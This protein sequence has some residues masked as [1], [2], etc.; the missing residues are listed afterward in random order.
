[1][2]DLVTIASF[3][4][5]AEAETLRVVLAD[6]GIPAFVSDAEVSSINF[7]MTPAVGGV[8][9][10]TSTDDAARA[11]ALIAAHGGYRY[12]KID[13]ESADG[14][15]HCLDC[16]A[17]I[18]DDETTCKKCGWSYAVDTPEEA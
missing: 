8:K 13:Y 6:E 2:S 15:M 9:L 5:A 7:L 16:G 1:M 14:S 4:T 3:Y 18:T 11:K 17:T 12:G 10:R